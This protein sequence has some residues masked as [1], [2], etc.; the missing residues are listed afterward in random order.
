LSRLTVNGDAEKSADQ[1]EFEW[2]V[3]TVGIEAESATV[4]KKEKKQKQR[5]ERIKR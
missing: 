1:L 3:Q 5:Q 2:A 4:H